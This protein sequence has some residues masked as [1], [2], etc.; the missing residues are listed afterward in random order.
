MELTWV[1]VI[2]LG[3]LFFNSLMMIADQEMID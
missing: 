2:S 1:V 3:I